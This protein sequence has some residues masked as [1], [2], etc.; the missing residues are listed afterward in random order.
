MEL[1]DYERAA[2]ATAVY[3]GRGEQAGLI[4][5]AMALGGEVGELQNLAKKILRGDFKDHA[6]ASANNVN[7]AGELGDVLWYVAAVAFELGYSLDE[8][9]AMNLGKL[10]S[11]KQHGTLKGG[12]RL[13]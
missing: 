5:A 13:T 11:R 9:A 6:S 10:A 1:Y 8:I 4:Y 3:N 7:M 12:R 2:G